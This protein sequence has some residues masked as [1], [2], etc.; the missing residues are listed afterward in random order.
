MHEEPVMKTTHPKPI[1]EPQGPVKA[2]REASDMLDASAIKETTL[3]LFA[4]LAPIVGS[5]VPVPQ[6]AS[7]PTRSQARSSQYASATSEAGSGSDSSV[8]L[9]RMTLG[10][11]GAAILRTRKEAPET[12]ATPSPVHT[13]PS[14]MRSFFDAAMERFLKE[15]QQASSNL[16]A[17][18]RD[19]AD[20]KL[21]GA[22]DVDMKS[23]GSAHSHLS[24]YD[25][26]GLNSFQSQYCG[27][28]V[29]IARQ[30]YH[31]RKRS[32]ESLLEYL[33]CLNVAGLR[34]QLS[35]KD[36]STEARREHVDHF[37]EA[38]DDRDLANQL[39]LLMIPDADTLEE[40][41][42]SQKRVNARQGKTVYGSIRPKPKAPAGAVPSANARA[43]RAV[44]GTANTCYSDPE[45]SGSEG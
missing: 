10:P 13:T 4:R 34:A 26:D 39:A 18:T 6:E 41:L 30:Y 16:P 29:S 3:N 35:I 5:V 25:P 38:L 17:A 31:A 36:G 33:Y 21:S 12:N 37:I 32:D 44:R 22:Q 42:R 24:E 11:S 8:E 23:V 45:T 28:G 20:P 43:V 15:Q 7:T 14:P 9:Q 2:P 40:T 1:G 27:R 19:P